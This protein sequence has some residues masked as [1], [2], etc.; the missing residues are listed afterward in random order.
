HRADGQFA[1]LFDAELADELLRLTV[2]LRQNRLAGFLLLLPRLRFELL[3]DVAG[4]GA[5]RSLAALV[6]EAELDGIIAIAI[7]RADLQNRARTEIDHRDG[8]EH[9]LVVED[10]GHAHLETEKAQGHRTPHCRPATRAAISWPKGKF[11]L[12][13]RMVRPREIATRPRRR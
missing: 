3:G 9:A 8:M 1:R 5:A 11:R 6:L 2:G 10:L 13:L 7:L 4:F 12:F